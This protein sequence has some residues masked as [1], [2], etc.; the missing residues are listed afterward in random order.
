MVGMGVALLPM[1]NPKGPM[2]TAP[3]DLVLG[4]AIMLVAIWAG[5]VRARVHLPYV[6]GAGGLAVTGL[7]AA[8][9]GIA[10]ITGV[11][12]VVQEVFLLA[13]CAAVTAVCRT[14]HGLKS[15]VRTWSISAAVWAVVVLLSVASGLDRVPGGSGGDGNRARLWFD[16]PNMAGNYFMIAFFIVL[17][18]RQPRHPLVRGLA[19]SALLMA[20]LLTG[21]NSAMSSLALGGLVIVVLR[22]RLSRGVVAAV[23]VGLCLV[24]AAGA[25]WSQVAQPIVTEAQESDTPVLRYSIGRGSRSATARSSLFESQY[26]L[27]RTSSPLGI[28][29]SAT[30]QVLTEIDDPISKQ[31]HND[32]LATLV[33][34]GPLGVL[35]LLAL[36]G[37]IVIRILAAQRLPPEW[38][39]VVPNPPALA[40]AAVGFAFTAITHEVL[41]YRQL[42][43]F[44]AVLAALH[45]GQ[46]TSVGLGRRPS[47]DPISSASP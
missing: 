4:P 27:F 35:A 37:A 47:V 39:A 46:R 1:L 17:A 43:T 26:D 2:N 25:L 23:A 11:T 22:V 36:I 10:P 41:H 8:M 38:A 5:T 32:Y 31:A 28:G 6:I 20:V 7:V 42:W 44:L 13:W 40:A 18:T 30:R 12:T 34:R 24:L 33:E 15:V 14:P 19:L 29:P 16:H 21:S 45:I 3:V 9:D